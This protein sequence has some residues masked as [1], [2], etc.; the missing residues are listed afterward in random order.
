MSYPSRCSQVVKD[1]PR[2]IITTVHRQS[3]SDLISSYRLFHVFI[4]KLLLVYHVY[5]STG[6]QDLPHRCKL[7]VIPEE[8]IYEK[9][10]GCRY[11]F[12]EN[13]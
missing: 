10:R 6:T 5:L 4:H 2:L 9:R 1:Y 7:H 11:L 13:I 8:I 3:F 12:Y